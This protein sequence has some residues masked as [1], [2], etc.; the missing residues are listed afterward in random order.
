MSSTPETA[1]TRAPCGDS[2]RG[3]VGSPRNGRSG[4]RFD[5]EARRAAEGT[6]GQGRQRGLVGPPERNQHA[7]RAG[8]AVP[9]ASQVEL[10][11]QDDIVSA[12]KDH[13]LLVF[14]SSSWCRNTRVDPDVQADGGPH[15]V[16]DQCENRAPLY[17]RRTDLI[18]LPEIEDHQFRPA[19]TSAHESRELVPSEDDD[20]DLGMECRALSANT[21][22]DLSATCRQFGAERVRA[23]VMPPADRPA[24]ISGQD[25]SR[26]SC[27][28][29]SYGAGGASGCSSRNATI[30]ANV[31]SL[32][33]PK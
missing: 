19:Q 5:R 28:S 6:E 25:L 27:A 23:D 2:T 9:R 32:R 1:R 20:G 16:A 31:K 4:D 21:Q 7:A 11:A 33:P 13:R 12:S 3:D 30:W 8:R 22:E 14:R 18:P 29:R 17:L 26:S 15:P 24:A 10:P